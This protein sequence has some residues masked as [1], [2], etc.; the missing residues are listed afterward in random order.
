MRRS[1]KSRIGIYFLGTMVTIYIIL[2]LLNSSLAI[3]ALQA[4]LSILKKVV[5]VFIVV[6]ALLAIMN[7]FVRPQ[8]LT[9]YLGKN[10]GAKGWI[11][12]IIAGIISSGPIY[13]WY[14]LLNELQKHGT[15][16][17]II[18]T[19]LYNRAVKP[20]LLPLMIF[21]FGIKFVAVL[22]VVMVF[23]SVAQGWLVE[24]LLEVKL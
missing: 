5:P 3:K 7:K 20:A 4:T 11:I 22:T 17:G 24:K 9:K 18:A 8:T 13:L 21:Y 15:R 1:E 14:P 19:F 2:G 23:V 10:S 16:N 12:A 6:I